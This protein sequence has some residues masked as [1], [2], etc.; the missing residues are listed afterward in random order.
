ME[1]S[2]PED[3]S[4]CRPSSTTPRL[5]AGWRWT[6]QSKLDGTPGAEAVFDRNVTAPRQPASTAMRPVVCCVFLTVLASACGG[7]APDGSSGPVEAVVRDSAGIRIVENPAS[8][9]QQWMLSPQPV[10]SIGAL[11]GTDAEMLYQV[12]DVERLSDGSWLVANGGTEEVRVFDSEGN[13]LRT[14]GRAGEGPGEFVSLSRVYVLPADSIAV[15]DSR[16]RR[17]TVFDPAGQTVRDFQ[18]ESLPDGTV[19]PFGRTTSGAWGVSRRGASITTGGT[20]RGRRERPPESLAVSQEDGTSP[21]LFAELLDQASWIVQAEGF[22]SVR[23][24]PF[25]PGNGLSVVGD[26]FVGGVTEVAELRI[27]NAEG[28]ETDRWRIM[29][30]P[31]AVTDGEWNAIRDRELADLEDGA[32]GLPAGW[33]KAA[34][35]FW[36]QV[37]RPEVRPAW[38]QI[39]P[40]ADGEVWLSE[41]IV[42]PD[43]PATWRVFDSGGTLIREVETPGGFAV[44]WIGDGVIAGV[45]VDEFDVEYMRVHELVPAG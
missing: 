14:V 8:P 21:Q 24:I 41:Y 29:E 1:R 20:G 9:R 6:E 39:R 37:D 11:D 15:Y 3:A 27:W 18:F 12:T 5:V 7:D 23:S 35:E 13:Y 28:V 43:E 30:E 19:S 44:H 17:V 32:E 22:V 25:A 33:T 34:E 10:L 16:Q 45:V 26:R 38:S 31:T 42:R 4:G 36:E 2:T 40:T